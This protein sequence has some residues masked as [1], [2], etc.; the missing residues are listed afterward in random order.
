MCNNVKDANAEMNQSKQELQDTNKQEVCQC[1]AAPSLPKTLYHGTDKK[2]ADLIDKTG[3]GG[4]HPKPSVMNPGSMVEMN[5]EVWCATSIKEAVG[6]K[7][8]EVRYEIDTEQV[9]GLHLGEFIQKRG[10]WVFIGTI[11]ADKMDTCC[12]KHIIKSKK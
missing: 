12:I 10:F 11:P 7:G 4:T 9:I 1:F 8:G 3:L 2:T 5:R 6:S